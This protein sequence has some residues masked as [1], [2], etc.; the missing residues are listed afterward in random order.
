MLSAALALMV[1]V[2]LR[3]APAE[4]AVMAAVGAV[5]STVTLTAAEVVVLPAAS[6]AT[7]VRVCAPSATLV[8]SQETVYG[9]AVSSRPIG[10]PS[11][12]KRT[13]STPTLSAA[14]ALMVTAPL[15]NAPD[16]GDVMATV[17]GVLSLNTVTVTASEVYSMP[18]RSRATAV[19]VCEA[20]VVVLV[21]HEIEYGSVVSGA[22]RLRPSS[23][24]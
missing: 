13:P 17:G 22:P 14:L 4:G 7:A 20:L 1:T 6:R 12:K 21:S 18:I 8:V 10:A 5:L 9:A 3:A 2:P 15:T 23:L 11:T 24:N 19:K 16:D